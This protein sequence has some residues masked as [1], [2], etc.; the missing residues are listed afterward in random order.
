MKRKNIFAK[1]SSGINSQ[2][3]GNQNTLGSVQTNFKQH[4]NN[5][6]NQLFLWIIIYILSSVIGVLSGIFVSGFITK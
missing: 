2:N 3:I 6:G 1:K 5:N 4:K